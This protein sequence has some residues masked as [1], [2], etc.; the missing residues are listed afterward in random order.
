[1][2]T[3]GELAER[4]KAGKWSWRDRLY[5]YFIASRPYA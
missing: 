2:P 3:I 4:R 1:V 5:V